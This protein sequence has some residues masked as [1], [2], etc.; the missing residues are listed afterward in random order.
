MAPVELSTVDK[1][2]RKMGEEC[3]EKNVTGM[4]DLCLW[5]EARLMMDCTSKNVSCKENLPPQTF[6][7]DHQAKAGRN[8]LKC[9][10]CAHLGVPGACCSHM[11]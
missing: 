10:S 4:T 9:S 7:E 5:K 1:A 2:Q 8:Y 3:Q 11:L 6:S